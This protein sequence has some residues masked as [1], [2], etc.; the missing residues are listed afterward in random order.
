MSFREIT[1]SEKISHL[2]IATL[3]SSFF[4][5]AGTYF[6]LIKGFSL[7][8]YAKNNA[9]VEGFLG[10]TLLGDLIFGMFYAIPPLIMI[11][12]TG[13]LID[14]RPHLL[15]KLTFY[16]LFSAS[17]CLFL[18]NFALKMLIAPI[19]LLLITAFLTSLAVLGTASHALY[20]AVT[21]WKHRGKGFAVGNLIFGLVVVFLL[22]LSGLLEMDF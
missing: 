20:G 8:E 18:F 5:I 11:G 12:I 7:I 15:G 10:T 16:S 13:N 19:T 2:F 21:K 1:K 6:F 3:P 17:I 4:W 22:I 9:L 14:K